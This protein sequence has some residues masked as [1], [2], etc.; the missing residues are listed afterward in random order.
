[1]RAA[2]IG[3][4]VGG[5]V[6][7]ALIGRAAVGGSEQGSGAKGLTIGLGAAGAG[8]GGLAAWKSYHTVGS[9]TSG[10]L[11]GVNLLGVGAVGLGVGAVIAGALSRGKTPVFTPLPTP[12]G[13][14]TPN[15]PNVPGGP[16]TPG[17]PSTPGAA[18]P[19]AA[20]ASM[21]TL[22]NDPWVSQNVDVSA[23]SLL[24]AGTSRVGVD[25]AAAGRLYQEL[26]S[27]EWVGA[28]YSVMDRVGLAIAGAEAGRTGTE[29][30]T[31]QVNVD[32]AL[33]TSGTPATADLESPSDRSMLAQAAVRGAVD[34]ETA[35]F[36]Y[37]GIRNHDVE[38]IDPHQAARLAAAALEGGAS[39][40]EATGAID[41]VAAHRATRALPKA[42]QITLAGGALRAGTTG[43][44]A[45]TDYATVAGDE[46]VK[47]LLAAGDL[48]TDQ[49]AR[50]SAA[51]TSRQLS[52]EDAALT[53]VN[54][55][56][57]DVVWESAEDYEQV[58]DLSIGALAG[59]HTGAEAATAFREVSARG[60]AT[61]SLPVSTR[62]ELAAAALAGT[63]TRDVI[64][65]FQ[66]SSTDASFTAVTSDVHDA[67][68][69]TGNGFD[70]TSDSE[71]VDWYTGAVG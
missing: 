24:A 12:G 50:L 48:S 31:T 20:S 58:V 71:L 35:A 34:G 37:A 70:A 16:S 46:W 8:L 64:A 42:D 61:A 21:S 43:T 29:V 51:A 25:G 57:D 59:L 67:M 11:R 68:L 44:Q 60:A 39:L 53:F 5:V 69:A 14:T 26:S 66:R 38:G 52:G 63:G 13:P 41:E 9:A 30:A 55:A 47:E 54:A 7:G 28:N 2:N 40:E 49:A 33:D 15:A 6:A 36:V 10:A 19:V 1:M 62:F 27:D 65:G 32:G 56:S 3:V 17:V 22:S 18:S 45:A 4:L 23:R